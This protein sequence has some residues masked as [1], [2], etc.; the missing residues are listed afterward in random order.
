MRRKYIYQ[1]TLEAGNDEFWE[2][3]DLKV[4]DVTNAIREALVCHGLLDPV[5]LPQRV[6]YDFEDYDD[7]LDL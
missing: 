6:I 5:I 7:P 1:I 3:P 4:A 2:D